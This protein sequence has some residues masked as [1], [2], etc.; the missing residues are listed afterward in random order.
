[1]RV[2]EETLNRMITESH[3]KSQI[4]AKMSFSK[5]SKVFL[6]K[7]NKTDSAQ[8]TGL[9]YSDSYADYCEFCLL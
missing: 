7:S 4:N 6:R 9:M 1:M 2:M 8:Q 5:L 3:I